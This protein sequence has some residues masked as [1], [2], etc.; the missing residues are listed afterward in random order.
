MSP[1]IVM[2]ASAG[3][4]SAL[5]R[6]F[7][8]INPRLRYPILV[9]QH[10]FGDSG[11]YLANKLNDVS[12]ISVTEAQDKMPICPGN[13]YIAPGDYHML[14]E[15]NMRISLS[16]DDRVTYSRPSIDVL[17]IS[18]ATIFK[19]NVLGIILTGAN[20]DGSDG[21]VHIKKYGGTVIAQDPREAESSTMPKSAIETGVVDKIITLDNIAEYINQFKICA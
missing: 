13:A 7:S 17:F 12:E 16:V 14:V 11:Q 19:S 10:L 5:N 15:K 20:H 8:Q 18:V 21:I 6:I 3:G 9:V 2:G 1:I 4:Y